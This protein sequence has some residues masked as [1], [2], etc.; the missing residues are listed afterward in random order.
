[1][2]HGFTAVNYIAPIR[3]RKGAMVSVAQVRVWGEEKVF[4]LLWQEHIS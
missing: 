1:M 3:I 4:V 2:Q